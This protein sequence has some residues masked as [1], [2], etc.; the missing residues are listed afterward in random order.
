MADKKSFIMYLDW[1]VMIYRLTD[2]EAGQLLK[3]LYLYIIEERDPDFTGAVAMAYDFISAQ[4]KRDTEKYHRVCEKRS[5]YAKRPR[6]RNC[7]QLANAT[8]TDTVTDTVPQSGGND[9]VSYFNETM[10]SLFK[11]KPS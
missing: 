10:E 8:D 7:E 3:A 11:R 2:E 5:V 4:I 1:A 9:S 6:R